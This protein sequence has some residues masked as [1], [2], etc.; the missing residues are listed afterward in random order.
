MTV[1]VALL[2]YGS[3]NIR[4]AHKAL[5]QV[6]TQVVVTSDPGEALSCDALLV[7]GVGA[8]AAC[9]QGLSA[10]NGPELITSFLTT[11]RRV[12]GICVGMQIMFDRGVEHGVDT[13]GCGVLSGVVE[14]LTAPVIPHMGWNT[15][16]P[17]VES[18]L[19]EGISDQ[20]FYFVHSYAVRSENRFGDTRQ[21][22]DTL[23]TTT[24]YGEPFV[25]AIEVGQLA[26]TQFHP[27]KSGDAGLQL[28]E[29]W[30]KS[31]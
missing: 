19:F 11:Q 21:T 6:G 17:P 8:F 13:R 18:Q 27:E 5:E 9:M 4:S 3:G 10:I 24:T 12:L 16:Q 25:A 1:C 29:N 28:L 2:D 22:G 7:P 30:A 15:V 14:S 20:R 23:V 31:I 26:A